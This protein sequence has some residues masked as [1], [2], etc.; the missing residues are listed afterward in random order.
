MVELADTLDL[1][2]SA[3]PA[4]GFE[5]PPSHHIYH[6]DEDLFV[7]QNTFWPRKDF[8]IP[9]K[10]PGDFVYACIKKTSKHQTK[11]KKEGFL[12]MYLR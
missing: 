8:S 3:L 10:L 7:H 1:G 5:S 9:G 11:D 4:W 6:S 2:S 12:W